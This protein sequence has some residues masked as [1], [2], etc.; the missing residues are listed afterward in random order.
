MIGINSQI[1]TTGGGG[2]GV[3]FAVPV[4]TVSRLLRELRADG[5]IDYAYLGVLDRC[6]R[7]WRERFGLPVERGALVQEVVEDG[8]ADDA[9]IRA[10][11]ERAG[12]RAGR[13]A[14]AAM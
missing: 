12:S 10:G 2:E 9:G 13:T 11:D 7:S 4:D 5:K 8:P 6:I 14:R 1:R 3:G